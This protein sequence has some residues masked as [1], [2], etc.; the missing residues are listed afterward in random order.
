MNKKHG[1]KFISALLAVLLFTTAALPSLKADAADD[2]IDPA[3]PVTLTVTTPEDM[4]ALKTVDFEVSIWRIALVD[5]NVKYTLTPAFDE[6]AFMG[7]T[8]KNTGINEHKD[9]LN[10]KNIRDFAYTCY[11]RTLGDESGREPVPA[12]AVLTVHNGTGT[13]SKT[14]YEEDL[15][16]GYYLIVPGNCKVIV[17]DEIYTFDPTLITLPHLGEEVPLSDGETSQVDWLYDLT[18]SPK[19]LQDTRKGSVKIVKILNG[20]NETLEGADFVFTVHATKNGKLEY[21]NV[22]SLHFDKEDW[23]NQRMSKEYIISDLPVGTWVEVKEVYEGSAYELVD[24]R[25]NF[26]DQL[27]IAEGTEGDI[28]TFTF[29]NSPNDHTPYGS[30]ALNHYNWITNTEKY[31]PAETPYKDS[32]EEESQKKKLN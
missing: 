23:A 19:P 6:L 8:I 1:S 17:G 28:L 4:P 10:N 9:L 14:S 21:S 27:V 15:L 18:I 30:S 2:H 22:I 11:E 26:P 20:F 16:P 13:V 5:E 32:T 12:D 29:W 7:Y 3:H 31:G 25:V 24:Q